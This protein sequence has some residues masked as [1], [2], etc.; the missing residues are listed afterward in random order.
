MLDQDL[1]LL[2]RWD[3]Q[4]FFCKYPREGYVSVYFH[5]VLPCMKNENYESSSTGRYTWT[6][7]CVGDGG[8]EKDLFHVIIIM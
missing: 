6:G 4:Q 7:L 5:S 3:M 8:F 1:D 2:L